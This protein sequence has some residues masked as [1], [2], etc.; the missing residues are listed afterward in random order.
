MEPCGDPAGTASGT[1]PGTGIVQFTPTSSRGLK[2]YKYV[3]IFY[4]ITEVALIATSAAVA[5]FLQFLICV[6]SMG[7]QVLIIFSIAWNIYKNTLLSF[8]ISLGIASVSLLATII[9]FPIVNSWSVASE[10]LCKDILAF[11]S[12]PT[13]LSQCNN[14]MNSR[15]ILGIIL[16]MEI[17]FKISWIICS[18]IGYK[19]KVSLMLLI[20]R[21]K[22]ERRLAKMKE[23]EILREKERRRK[24]RRRKDLKDKIIVKK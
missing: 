17:A 20:E 22:S 21:I 18:V 12:N 2:F 11:S 9:M 1:M 3:S 13:A 4:G 19:S 15:T 16:I 6:A 7:F 10:L 24:E 14:L 23:L 5:M 8:K